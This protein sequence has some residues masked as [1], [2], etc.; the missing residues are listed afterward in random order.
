MASLDDTL[1][2]QLERLFLGKEVKTATL[3]HRGVLTEKGNWSCDFERRFYFNKLFHPR[4]T[5]EFTESK[6]FASQN[7]PA[8]IELL[9]AGLDRMSW[10]KLR[11]CSTSSTRNAIAED[12]WQTYFYYAVGALIP[13]SMV[14]SKE[15]VGEKGQL[16]VVDFVLRDGQTIAIELLIQSHLIAE[17][18]AR[19]DEDAR[20]KAL[21][22]DSWVICDIYVASEDDTRT[23]E[24]NIPS[25]VVSSFALVGTEEGKGR[26]AVF[27]VDAELTRGTLYQYKDQAIQQIALE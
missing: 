23:I 12:A 6:L 14:F 21:E 3:H 9:A 8:P 7:F 4:E 11:V 2:L 18:H 1:S 19:F 15:P 5:R 22:I 26:H 10:D 13:Q 27:Y 25:A 16:G 24:D 17:H 20:Y